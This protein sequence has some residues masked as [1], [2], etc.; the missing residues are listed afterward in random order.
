VKTYMLRT[1]FAVSNLQFASEVIL[2]RGK[3]MIQLISRR[4]LPTTIYKLVSTL[5]DGNREVQVSTI[6]RMHHGNPLLLEI[7]TSC[8][9]E[10]DASPL[11]VR[12]MLD[13]QLA[14]SVGILTW[15]WPGVVGQ[16]LGEGMF[17]QT[18]DDDTWTWFDIEP[19][20]ITD[21]YE[22]SD[23]L[24]WALADTEHKISKLPKERQSSAE[25]AIRWWQ[26]SHEV[27]SPA[28]RLVA[29]WII[30]EII[31]YA[32]YPSGSI[33]KRVVELLFQVFPRLAIEKNDILIRKMEK[34]LSEARNRAV[35]GGKRDITNPNATVLVARDAAMASISFFLGVPVTIYP[36]SEL[37]KV[38]GIK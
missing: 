16:K 34:V 12:P 15:S 8:K 6:N 10:D 28:D 7:V 35:H 2:S 1:L 4:E 19:I 17:T 38:L 3:T 30:L 33:H 37:L 24:S 23:K 25:A 5:P 31:S 29:Y 13:S 20:H 32:L 11:V 21:C 26:H 36:S 14:R 9:A 18:S 22:S 27:D